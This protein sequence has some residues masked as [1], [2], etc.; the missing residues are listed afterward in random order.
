V[1][2][3]AEPAGGARPVGVVLAGGAGSRAGGA[4]PALPLAGRPLIAHPLA[5]LAAVLPQVAVVAKAGTELPELPGAARWNE[6]DEPRHP[7][8]GIVE[9]LRRADGRP[10]VVL[11][12][13]LPLVTPR[14]VRELAETPAAGAPALVAESAGRLQPLCAR[15]EPAAL[16]L[17]AGFDP[18]GRTV[19]Q[20]R[21]LGP[22]LLDVEPEL[23]FN[24]ND[25]A[26][27]AEAEALLAGR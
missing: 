18:D 7:L 1:S 15:Y 5:A 26:Q 13:D 4:K 14:L 8:A 23:L 24:V 19:D 6:P 10:V 12:C 25:T 2:H 9:A 20:V 3:A 16:S 17:L 21:A 22:A 27:L 11:A